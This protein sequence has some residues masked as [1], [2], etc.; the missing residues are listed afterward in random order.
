MYLLDWAPTSFVTEDFLELV[1]TISA[2]SGCTFEFDEIFFD[3]SPFTSLETRFSE[4]GC[5]PLATFLVVTVL[6]FLFLFKGLIGVSRGAPS[7]EE[8]TDDCSAVTTVCCIS[9]GTFCSVLGL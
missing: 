1:N 3:D 8:G 2:T 4:S 7:L 9:L 6:D 5:D